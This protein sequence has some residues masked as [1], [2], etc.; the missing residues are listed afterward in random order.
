MSDRSDVRFDIRDSR[1]DEANFIMSSWLRVWKVSP[2]A[3]CIPNHLFRQVT[4][5]AIEQLILRGARFRVAVSG[6]RI[7]GWM[8]SEQTRRGE[9]VV[10]AG[11]CRESYILLGVLEALRDDVEG[12]RPIRYTHRTRQLANALGE[13]ARHCPEIARRK[14]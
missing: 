7:L 2:F 4:R 9:A 6:D 13:S 3:G 1:P 12:S 10:H 14:E 5:T 11:Y 8:C